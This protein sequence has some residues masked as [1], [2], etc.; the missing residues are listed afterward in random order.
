[1]SGSLA[2]QIE[3]RDGAVYI[4]V[5]VVPGSKREGVVGIHGGALKIAVRAR[6]QKGK[7]NAALIE[8]ISRVAGV[9]R[10]A[11]EVVSGHSSRRKRVRIDGAT[12]HEVS[13][14]VEAALGGVPGEG[15]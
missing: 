13:A 4:D 2:C 6:P 5:H 1:L 3:E 15:G 8:V 9:K 12:A 7:A 11:V 10:S 14:R